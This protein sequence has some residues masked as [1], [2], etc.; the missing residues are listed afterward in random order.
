MPKSTSRQP[1]FEKALEELEAVVERLEDG[2]LSLEE[3]LKQFERGIK[4][5]RQCQ[6]ALEGA[7]QKVRVL[8]GNGEQTSLEDFEGGNEHG[9][10]S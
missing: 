1:D 6:E 3:A 2:E 9:T 4:L 8:L 10:Q 5:T 7:E